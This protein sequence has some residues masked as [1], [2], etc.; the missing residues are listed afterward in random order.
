M[1]AVGTVAARR[2]G[3]DFDVLIV[4]GSAGA[5]AA[6][7]TML[8]ALGH[9]Q[10]VAIV[11]LHQAPNGGDLA[12]LFQSIAGM[13]CVTVE[14]K[15]TATPGTVYFAPSGYH[16][17]VERSGTFA[18]SVDAPVNWSRPSIDVSFDSAAEVYGPRLVGLLLTGASDDGARGL[19]TIAARGGMVIVQ[20]PE[21]AEVP[22]MP[23]AAIRLGMP[24]AVLTIAQMTDLFAAWSGTAERRA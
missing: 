6:L 8:P 22:L 3:R 20:A 21:D 18:L 1:S 24:D 23:T 17:L 11:V 15:L 14:D 7:R 10:L 19:R 16:L 5:F 2:P 4:G 13:P 12:E 9:P